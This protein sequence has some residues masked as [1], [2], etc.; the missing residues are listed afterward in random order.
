MAVPVI[1]VLMPVYNAGDYIREAIESILTQTFSD[2]EFLIINDGSTD[3]TENIILSYTDKRI[4][5][6]KN[7]KNIGL[8]ATLNKGISL[9]DTKYMARM[10]ADD[11]AFQDRLKVQYDFME[12]NPEIGVSG[13]CF[14]IFG[15]TNQLKQHPLSD[16][17]IKANLLFSCVLCHPAVILRTALL[18]KNNIT[19]GVTFDYDDKFEHRILELED[20]GLWHKLKSVT[21]F[22][23]IN[24]PLIKYRMIGQNLSTKKEDIILERKKQFYS[25]VLKELNIVPN[26]INLLLH[27][28]PKYIFK[29][30]S[31]K[32]IYSFKSYLNEILKNNKQLKI[33]NEI[34]LEKVVKQ[35][36]IHLFYFLPEH[37]YK[38]VYAYLM[39]SKGLNIEQVKYLVIFTINKFIRKRKLNSNIN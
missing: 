15:N 25:H 12:A 18:K 20:F 2:F 9:T 19:Y 28:S 22:E 10:D 6:V 16:L 32:D 33:Y 4:K 3:E 11:I 35:R 24:H 27:I 13:G 5:Y 37:N 29:S 8:T 30:K 26:N 36:W 38:S 21:N 31:N 17:E 14:E 1:S 34:E 39:L 23:N 7:D